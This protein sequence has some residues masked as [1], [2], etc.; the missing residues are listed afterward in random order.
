MN[1]LP[2]IVQLPTKI[3]CRC[4]KKLPWFGGRPGRTLEG[5]MIP[6]NDVVL[7]AIFPFRLSSRARLAVSTTVLVTAGVTVLGLCHVSMSW[8]IAI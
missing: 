3:P 8:R 2:Q 4:S 1:P 7:A 5:T 6:L